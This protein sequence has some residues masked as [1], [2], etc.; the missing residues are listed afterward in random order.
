MTAIKF[1]IMISAVKI[2]MKAGEAMED[3]LAS[4][5]ALTDEDREAIKISILP[6]N[7]VTEEKP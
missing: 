6:A 4:Y 2:R 7:N 3:I 5:T 1:K